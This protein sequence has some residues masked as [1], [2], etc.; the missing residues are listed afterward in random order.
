[1]WISEWIFAGD[2]T[3]LEFRALESDT[4]DI[5]QRS[6]EQDNGTCQS[7]EKNHDSSSKMR[8]HNIR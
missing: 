1:M 5:K 4:M 3:N 6:S 8:Y 2:F 7:S